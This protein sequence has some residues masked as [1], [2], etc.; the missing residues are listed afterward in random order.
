[1][2]SID[3][4]DLKKTDNNDNCLICHDNLCNETSH[5]LECGHDYHVDC[6]I[7]WFRSGNVNC[8]YCNAKPEEIGE[9][10]DYYY[11]RADVKNKYSIIK[12]FSRRK[13]CPSYI[14]RK[15]NIINKNEEKLKELKQDLKDIKNEV[16]AYSEIVKKHRKK[17]SKIWSTTRTIFNKKRDLVSVVNI[18]PIT[19]TNNLKSK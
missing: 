2:I 18:I 3:P 10:A 8:P 6:I 13:N 16:G 15:I 1:M 19:I 12:K 7:S 5:Q 11:S 14:K 9:T 4:F 17:N